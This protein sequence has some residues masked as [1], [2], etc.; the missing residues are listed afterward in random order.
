MSQILKMGLI[1]CCSSIL[2]TGA[3][4]ASVK[5]YH[6]CLQA[7]VNVVGYIGFADPQG[8]KAERAAFEVD[9]TRFVTMGLER[10]GEKAMRNMMPD[11][12]ESFIKSMVPL[13]SIDGRVKTTTMLLEMVAPCGG[14]S[15]E[16]R[17]FY[18]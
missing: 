15:G 16:L 6:V 8:M 9:F 5:N 18:Q 10:Y 17:A 2:G 4:F 7:Y 11:P 12:K 13:H 14:P 1:A 3:T